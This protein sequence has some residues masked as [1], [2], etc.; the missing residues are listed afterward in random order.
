MFYYLPPD[1]IMPY[2]LMLAAVP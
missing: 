2:R 1:A